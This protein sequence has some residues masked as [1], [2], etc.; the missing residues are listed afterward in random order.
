MD[1]TAVRTEILFERSLAVFCDVK[2]V[3]DKFVDTLVFRSG[4]R[5]DRNAKDVLHKVDVDGTAVACK[6]VHHVE[7]DDDRASG[8]K[9]LHREI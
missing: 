5:N 9:K 2:R 3:G 1:G 6:F 8:L 4:D 7:G